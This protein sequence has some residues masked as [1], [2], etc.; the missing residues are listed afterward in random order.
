MF[1]PK[2]LPPDKYTLANKDIKKSYKKIKNELKSYNSKLTKK[3]ELVILNKTD[4]L[5]QKQIKKISDEL[6]KSIKSEVI[7]LSTFEKG[8]VSKI[9]SKLIKYAS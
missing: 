6:G 1:P 5:D 4:L 7:L 9:K 2:V 3:K 8:S